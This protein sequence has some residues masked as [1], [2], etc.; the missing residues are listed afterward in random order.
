MLWSDRLNKQVHSWRDEGLKSPHIAAYLLD[1]YEEQLEKSVAGNKDETLQSALK[2]GGELQRRWKV[3]IR[4]GH[5][6]ESAINSNG[7]SRV[8]RDNF[9]STHIISLPQ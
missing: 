3:A 2:V 5:E 1:M 8:L 9:S 4:A 6:S 7:S